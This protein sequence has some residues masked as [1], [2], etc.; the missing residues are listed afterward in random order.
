[1]GLNNKMEETMTMKRQSDK[2]DLAAV[3]AFITKRS[4]NDETR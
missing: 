2:I 4:T 3:R 1:V